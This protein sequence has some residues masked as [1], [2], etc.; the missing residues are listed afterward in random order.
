MSA[1]RKGPTGPSNTEVAVA[2]VFSLALG[3]IIG[4]ALLVIQPVATVKELPAE[5]DRPR[6]AVYLVEG[7]RDSSKSA[8]AIRKRQL[9]MGGQS[10]SLSEEELN[11]VFA[12]P[13]PRP[14][15]K[16]TQPEVVIAGVFAVGEPNL[17]IADGLIQLAAPVRL[18][19]PDLG[20]KFIAQVRGTMVKKADGFVFEPREMYLGGCP[21]GAFPFVGGMIRARLGT[22]EVVPG[23]LRANWAR[24]V[25]ASVDGRLLRLRLP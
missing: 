4:A 16:T 11:L 14:G 10:V 22:V 9:F 7:G 3:A 17:R 15:E 12:S 18:T 23:E 5:K 6:G 2:A 1:S 13:A 24:L 21:L 20:V 8:E 25:D 19:L